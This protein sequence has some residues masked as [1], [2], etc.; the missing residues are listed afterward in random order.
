M[1]RASKKGLVSA[2]ADKC[3]CCGVTII[4]GVRGELIHI[5][6][7]CPVF[8]TEREILTALMPG[9]PDDQL[10][11]QYILGGGV[12][13]QIQG[14]PR[15]G[16]QFTACN[17]WVRVRPEENTIRTTDD[18][19]SDSDL[20]STGTT[21]RPGFAIVAEFLQSTMGKYMG[22]VWA[23]SFDQIKPF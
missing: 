4:D 9:L 12:P 22:H 20:V 1:W 7:Y 13:D 18:T 15:S 19:N 5:I 2:P 16:R 10:R 11:L 8:T 23:T 6:F 21:T 14:G 3:P 17:N